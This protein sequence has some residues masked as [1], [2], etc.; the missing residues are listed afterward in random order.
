MPVGSFVKI[1]SRKA[2]KVPD[3]FAAAWPLLKVASDFRKFAC[4]SLLVA[5]LGSFMG[6]ALRTASSY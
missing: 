5:P 1:D 2:P 3:Q 6:F 4:R